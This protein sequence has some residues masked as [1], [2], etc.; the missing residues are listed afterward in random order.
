MKLNW[1]SRLLFR[2]DVESFDDAGKVVQHPSAP[3]LKCPNCQS[4]YRHDEIFCR[5]CGERLRQPKAKAVC[6]SCGAA[7]PEPA[8]FCTSCGVPMGES[9]EAPP[10]P[11]AP[12]PRGGQ[13]AEPAVVPPELLQPLMMEPPASVPSA[14][15]Q[16]QPAPRRARAVSARPAAD[17][18]VR[19]VAGLLD[20]AVVGLI[21]IGILGPLAY[22][23]WTR[24]LTA[25]VPFLPILASVA[26][27]IATL[28]L[29]GLY[30]AYFW[31][32]RGATYS[33]RRSGRETPGAGKAAR[34]TLPLAVSGIASSGTKCE[35][36]MYWGTLFP[37]NSRRSVVRTT[38]VAFGTT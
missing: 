34:S 35:G 30:F 19:L 18:I 13:M 31:G 32:V 8:A 2:D 5:S 11:P 20:V 15:E 36:T 14:A 1:S 7:T 25:E 26:L 3:R 10:D 24:D 21:Q 16:R 33:S 6:P 38:S 17:W 12:A 37:R 29:G 4:N 27:L 22:S 23:W 28:A 9:H